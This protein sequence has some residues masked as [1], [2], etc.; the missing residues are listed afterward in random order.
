MANGH[1]DSSMTRV[2]PVFKQLYGR[3]PAGASWLA[4]LLALGSRRE[5]VGLPKEQDWTG[6]L[7]E[8][9]QFE[10]P[11]L[12]PANYL[13][14]LVLNPNELDWR[15]LEARP[16]GAETNRMRTQLRGSNQE[17][18]GEAVRRIRAGQRR[19]GG[20]QWHVFEGTTKVDCA[21]TAKHVTVFVEG[22]RTESTLTERVTW[23][24]ARHQIFRNLDCLRDVCTTRHYYMMLIVEEGTSLMEQAQALDQNADIAIKS[25]PHL[26]DAGRRELFSHYLGFT[27][28]QRIAEQFRPMILPH[29]VTEAN[30]RGL[31]GPCQQ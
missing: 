2:R 16:G 31:T 21:I 1:F 25:W 22:K 3:D 23:H 18:Q 14:W 15:Q 6:A 27:T 17:V 29:N 20:G 28:W 8:C 10:R 7:D 4:K 5:D 12:S 26:L 24:Q 11:E 19:F 30:A 13:E 9:P